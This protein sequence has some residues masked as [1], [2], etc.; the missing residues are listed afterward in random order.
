MACHSAD[1]DSA[2][3]NTAQ[4]REKKCGK[5]PRCISQGRVRLIADTSPTDTAR[6]KTKFFCSRIS[7][8]KCQNGAHVLFYVF[9]RLVLKYLSV[10]PRCVEFDSAPNNTLCTSSWG[11]KQKMMWWLIGSAP[12][13]WGRGPGFCIPSQT[14]FWGK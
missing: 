8:R 11:L 6:S 14:M 4:I 13:F 3:T 5:S 12:D 9:F 2:P 10:T 7:V 1:S